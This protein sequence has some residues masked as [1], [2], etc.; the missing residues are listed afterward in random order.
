M[1]LLA[2]RTSC[3][4]LVLFFCL[5]TP[6]VYSS[7]I[8]PIVIES[9]EMARRGQMMEQTSLSKPLRWGNDVPIC[10]GDVSGGISATYDDSGY[11]YAARCSTYMST[12][13]NAIRIY[14]STNGGTTW[15]VFWGF[16]IMDHHPTMPVLLT[17]QYLTNNW[18]YIFY[19]LDVENG[20]IGMARVKLD[21]TGVYNF[22]SVVSGTDTVTYFSACT[23]LETGSHLMVAYQQEENW[24]RLYTIASSDYGETWGG[25]T[26]V[27]SDGAHPDITYGSNGYVYVVFESTGLT[28]GKSVVVDKEIWFRRN[29]NYCAPGSWETIESLT[30]DY[31]EDS[32]PKVAALH[33]AP[34]DTA[35]IWVAYNHDASATG[36]LDTLTY[37]DDTPTWYFTIPDSYG[38]D[39]FNVRFTPLWGCRLRS[40]QFLFYQKVGVGA[41]RIY[42]WADTNGYPAEKIDSVYVPHADI[43]FYPNWTTI[44]FLS[45]N[46]DLAILSDFHIGYTPLGAPATDTLSIIS[47]NGLPVG[48]E[49]RSSEFSGGAWG[50]M[51]NDWGIDVNFMIRAIIERVTDP[52][53][54]LRYAY[55]TNSGVD[56]VKDQI[57]AG[58]VSYDEMACNLHAYQSP[59]WYWVDLCYLRWPIM[60]GAP[61]PDICYTWSQASS[62]HQ[63]HTPH[64]TLADGL[65]HW[66]QD[67]REVCQVVFRPASV[68]PGVVYAGS[69]PLKEDEWNLIDGAWNLYFD[70]HDMTGVEEDFA[71]EE[72]A[73]QFF[74]S[75]NYPNPFNPE[76]RIG[77]YIPKACPVKLEVFNILGQRVKTLVDENQTAG[78]KEVTW[79]G[80]DENANEV[81]SGI[82]FYRLQAQDFVETKKMVLMK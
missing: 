10:S 73:T 33:T 62:A 53:T 17:G 1:S 47:D 50:T 32:Y 69:F 22:Y 24:H 41:V 2:N 43:Q 65:P 12:E 31:D 13:R 59:S 80:K 35:C 8:K 45:K 9:D 37:D 79:N 66:S 7:E 58:E 3:L 75:T 54:D 51:Y 38:D 20:N 30:D 42:V 55:S 36:E 60:R 49:H 4:L 72:L 63:F 15:Q 46:T 29:T 61:K 57:V 19:L 76:T 74:L 68:Y 71:E 64:E 81:A 52:N 78:A 82:Y 5:M 25:E 77:Y 40:A 16:A 18:L 67:S 27:C 11:M 48:M 34:E 28:K 14:R 70:H 44:D 56:W 39:L 23:D 21:D 26:L 6:A